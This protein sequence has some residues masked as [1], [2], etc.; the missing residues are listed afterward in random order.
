MP[1]D[2]RTISWDAP[3]PEFSEFEASWRETTVA[4]LDVP[5]RRLDAV[6]DNLNNTHSNGGARCAQ[7]SIDARGTVRWLLERN[8]PDEMGFFKR[9]FEHEVV[10]ERLVPT[11]ETDGDSNLGFKLEAPFV[12]AGRLAHILASGGAYGR[13]EGTDKEV[14][15]LVADFADAAFE[16]RYFE[17]RSHLSWKPWSPWFK[18]IAWDGSFY[19][20]DPRRG[21][22]QF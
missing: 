19:W 20:F 8:R 4:W 9:F 5:D 3:R 2:Y 21:P 14:Q 6:V 10:R 13:F 11:R 7:F 16:G 18:D 15:S 1:P 12:A 22:P 17:V